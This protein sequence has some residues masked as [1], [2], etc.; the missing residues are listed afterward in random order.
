M[1]APHSL[2]VFHLGGRACALPVERVQEIAPMA[3]LARPPGLV[4][5]IE[6]FLNLRGTA[7]PVLRLDLLFHLPPAAPQLYTP[8]IV[9]RDSACPVALCVERVAWI[10]SPPAE[11]LLPIR[12]RHCCN[13]CAESEVV[14]DQESPAIHVLSADR[15]LLEKE[16][17]CLAQLQA[18]AQRRLSEIES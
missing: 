1:P 18:E 10:I 8:L 13:D 7:V 5:F 11:A 4:S 3:R 14:L 6:G 12:E 9:L 2:L 16:R 15:L 17:Q